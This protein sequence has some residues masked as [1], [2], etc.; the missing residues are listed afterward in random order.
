MALHRKPK[1]PPFLNGGQRL[2]NTVPKKFPDP[3][4]VGWEAL[5]DLYRSH[6]WKPVEVV[7][8]MLTKLDERRKPGVRALIREVGLKTETAGVFLRGNWPEWAK[9][10]LRGNG[11]PASG[12]DVESDFHS[13]FKREREA[14]G[15]FNEGQEPPVITRF[16]RS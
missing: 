15:N 10:V 9:Y 1:R 4:R 2:G 5:L 12:S 7:V 3:Q 8:W 13:K 6:G 11:Y 14:S 16:P